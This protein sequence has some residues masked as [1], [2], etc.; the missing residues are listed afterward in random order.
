MT[1][2]EYLSKEKHT[3]KENAWFAK[4]MK[5]KYKLYKSAFHTAKVKYRKHTTEKLSF[6]D[7]KRLY[8]Q[9]YAEQLKNLGLKGFKTAKV[10]ASKVTKTFTD[11]E[12]L[13]TL[14][15]FSYRRKFENFLRNQ[16][17]Y[18]NKRD[19]GMPLT[20][21]ETLV[22]NFKVPDVPEDEVPIGFIINLVNYFEKLGYSKEAFDS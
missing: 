22:A 5:E 2:E 19:K 11:E 12:N 14:S 9:E 6:A 17:R 1:L 13:R 10:I 7:F 15:D 8:K 3:K 4:Q 20:A 21:A 16:K 18:K